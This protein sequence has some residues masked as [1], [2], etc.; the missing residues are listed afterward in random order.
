M[1]SV[2]KVQAES[3]PVS[4]ACHGRSA[5]DY[6]LAKFAIVCAPSAVSDPV[7]VSVRAYEGGIERDIYR[8]FDVTCD[9]SSDWDHELYRRFF[10]PRTL[11]CLTWTRR[12][13]MP[14]SHASA[15]ERGS[16][17]TLDWYMRR[18]RA[19]SPGEIRWRLR[20]E[21][22]ETADRCFA[23]RSQCRTSIA[24]IANGNG[25]A[26]AL[27][28]SAYG[29]QCG[30]TGG[31]S[32]GSSVSAEGRSMVIERAPRLM[33]NRFGFLD[34]VDRCL[35]AKVVREPNRHQH[36]VPPGRA[37]P[38]TREVRYAE[39]IVEQLE[40]WVDGLDQSEKLGS[41]VRGRRAKATCLRW[42]PDD[43]GGTVSGRHDG[44]AASA[45]PVQHRR[46]RPATTLE[47]RCK[48]RGRFEAE[49]RIVI[50]AKH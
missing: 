42:E 32:S 26:L 36:V 24:R 31:G 46:K 34:L 23:R 49:T 3:R 25:T 28:G 9:G 29:D 13:R 45:D 4:R 43:E 8:S 14:V 22:Q 37:N 5:V 11:T 50:S 12:R 27:N 18:L 7:V 1:F 35:D 16:L 2:L 15:V 6:S 21:A 48:W 38:L 19:M 20:S 17:Q 47:A 10:V 30:L 41:V 44:Y 33:Q 39:K 40:T